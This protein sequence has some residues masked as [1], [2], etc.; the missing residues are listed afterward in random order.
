MQAAREVSQE[1]TSQI[2]D[3][4][5][6]VGMSRTMYFLHHFV[7]N[8]LKAWVAVS[9]IC[10]IVGAAL[11]SFGLAAHLLL[12]STLMVAALIGMALTIGSIFKKPMQSTI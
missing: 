12:A 7:F 2:K 10:L 3:Y 6:S 5:L 1:A 11:K 4:L 8:F 9:G